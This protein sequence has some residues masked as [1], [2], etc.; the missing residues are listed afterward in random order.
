MTKKFYGTMFLVWACNK[1]PAD[2]PVQYILLIESNPGMDDALKKRVVMKMM[3]QL[4]FKYHARDE[5]QRRIID[6]FSLIDLKEWEEKYPQYP[7]YQM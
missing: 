4:P 7:I 5:I 3:G 2:K 6:E 1:N